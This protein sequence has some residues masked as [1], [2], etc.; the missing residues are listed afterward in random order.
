MIVKVLLFHITNTKGNYVY[1]L[2]THYIYSHVK[3]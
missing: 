2:Y 1:D 3:K